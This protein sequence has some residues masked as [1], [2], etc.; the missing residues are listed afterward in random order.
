MA[1]DP[2]VDIVVDKGEDFAFQ[3]YWTDQYD[4]PLAV[5]HPMK[6]MVKSLVGSV[7]NTYISTSDTPGGGLL[8]YLTYNQSSGLIQ[9]SLPDSHTNGLTPGTYKYDLWANVLDPD[10][11]SNTAKRTKLF[12]GSFVVVDA[13]TTF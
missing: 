13:V 3:A 5:S 4:E 1:D 10:D 12:G 11:L 6:M 8:Q 2:K 9:L 7:I